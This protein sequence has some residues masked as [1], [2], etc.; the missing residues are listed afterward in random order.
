MKARWLAAALIAGGFA[1]YGA[2]ALP[3][4]RQAAAAAD[5]DRR[6]RD[7]ARDIRL[8]LARLERRDAAHLRATTVLASAGNP[9]DTVRAVRR[10]IVQG[11]GEARVSGVHLGV[12]AGRAPYA[13]RVHLATEGPFSEVVGLTGLLARPERGLVLERVHLSPRGE[14]VS[15][16]LEAVTLG[17]GS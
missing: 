14:R 3:M 6:A 15:L 17:P 9:G 16:D 12:T 11:L 8:R 10:S 2:V 5:D 7:E 13:V 1:L 4:Q